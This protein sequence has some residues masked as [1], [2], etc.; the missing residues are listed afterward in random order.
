MAARISSAKKQT[1]SDRGSAAIDAGDLATAEQCFREAIR[2]DRRS[3]R[4]HFHLALVLEARAKFGAAAEHLTQ[5]LR[6]NPSDADA[7]RRL[8]TLLTHRPIPADIT[9]D[10]VGLRAAL[11]HDAS[12]S[13]LIVKLALY[14]LTAKGPLA[15]AIEVGKREGWEAAARTLCLS[16][17]AD[18]LKNELFLEMLRSEILRDADMEY[19]LS[20][21]RCV[22]LLETPAERFEDRDLLRFAI[23]LMQQA[24]AN[25]YC[26]Y[27]SEAEEARL[28]SEAPF[29][30]RLLAGDVEE[31]RKLLLTLLY[32]SLQA[33]LGGDAHPEAFAKM[34]PKALR[35][36]VQAALA[37]DG[38]LRAR[39]QHVPQLGI[40]S[41]ETSRKVARQYEV[42][43][44]PRWTSLRRPPPGEEKRRLETFFGVGG[45]AFMDA[46]YNV[47][48][49]GC[50]TGH[51]A[52]HWALSAPN[53]Q[54]TAVDLS[55]SALAYACKMAERYGTQ[56]VE[57]QQADIQNLPSTPGIAGRFHIIE[58]LGVLH[59]MADPYAGWRALIGCLAP[60][61]KLL[62]GLYSATARRL[63]TEL[64]SDPAF[65]G[66]GCEERAL[67]KFRRTLLDR[68]AEQPG[69]QLKLGP[70]FYSASEFRDLAA[71]VS[72]RCVT[73]AEVR[74][75]LAENSLAFRGF[76]IDQ[77][78][79][80]RF[81]RQ[82]PAEPW[83]GR[84]EAWE[85][86]E[87]ANPHTF[88][89]MYNFWCERA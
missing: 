70:D 44:Y 1:W 15:A 33:T 42:N 29:V 41:D 56:N 31:S 17:T 76:W 32:R 21:V 30:P 79:L 61:G 48:I 19:L 80:D 69:G 62:V 24:R 87:A 39:A 10:P 47:L 63:I 67:R 54:V 38:D 55:V 77:T 35:D 43:P 27:A 14:S 12:A 78:H 88:A 20:A 64:T 74:S 4:H 58:C 85:E 9:L 53:A 86:F 5:A 34:R 66:P 75:F 59:H 83:P 28:A 11:Q 57:F 3:A 73:L 40:I 84:L 52:V 81:H 49:A 36:A 26:W 22:L 37:E 23:T 82:F 45:L 68:P 7:A 13:W 72:E 18:A 16:R 71:H 2:A 50:G 89:A 60:Q 25:E 8:T 51:Q 6:L 65:P 46:P